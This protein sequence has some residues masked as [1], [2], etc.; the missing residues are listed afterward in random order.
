MT[1]SENDKSSIFAEFGRQSCS[2]LGILLKNLLVHECGHAHFL[3]SLLVINA[4]YLSKLLAITEWVIQ[5]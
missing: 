5:L 2:R 1:K 4:T 3:F